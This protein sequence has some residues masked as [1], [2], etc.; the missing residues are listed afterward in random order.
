MD[1]WFWSSSG[2][3]TLADILLYEFELA[4]CPKWRLAHIAE[5]G[6]VQFETPAGEELSSGTDWLIIHAGQFGDMR[7]GSSSDTHEYFELNYEQGSQNELIIEFNHGDV[8]QSITTEMD[9]IDTIYF[10]GGYG[11]DTLKL[12]GDWPADMR[13][14]FDGGIDSDKI[15][16]IDDDDL[17]GIALG[18][19]GNDQLLVS[20]GTVAWEL[21][22]GAGTDKI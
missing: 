7:G 9:G 17:G 3:K 1:V 15:E 22:G 21:W 20:A 11:S 8:I 19:S 2:S 13:I 5:N 18:G 16:M 12:T 10:D 4:H 6:E 14:L